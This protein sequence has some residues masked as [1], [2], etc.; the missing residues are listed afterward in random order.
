MGKVN[1]DNYIT[2]QGWMVSDLELKGNELLVYAIIYG[3]SQDGQNKFT[4]SLQYLA[5]WTNS[6]KQGVQ[7]NL[8]SLVDRGLLLK[9]DYVVSGVKLC[10]YYA[11]V[12]GMQQSCI[13]MQQSLTNSIVN[14]K[15]NSLSK[16]NESD[17]SR[18]AGFYFGEKPKPKNNLYTK[19]ISMIDE[20]FA[21]NPKI[22]ALLV[23]FLNMRLEMRDK[24]MYTNQWK[25]LLNKLEELHS[26]GFDYEKVI[27]YSIEHGYASFYEVDNSRKPLNPDTNK[28][29][30]KHYAT[31]QELEQSLARNSDGSLKTF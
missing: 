15:T 28:F 21:D 6:T 2:I 4:G 22:N 29:L 7:K 16:D 12:D 14:N 25:G 19:C 18:P 24:P 13:P 8:K 20:R 27:R 3:F 23:Q 31:E 5:D 1:P 26:K 9:E 17:I 30:Q 10:K 11:V